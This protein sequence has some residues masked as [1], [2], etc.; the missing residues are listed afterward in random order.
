ML[1][2]QGAGSL[3]FVQE[4]VMSSAVGSNSTGQRHDKLTVSQASSAHCGDIWGML[5]LSNLEQTQDQR[6]DPT[7]QV[8]N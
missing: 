6:A 8:E 4:K 1:L 5:T 7:T 2:T 3:T